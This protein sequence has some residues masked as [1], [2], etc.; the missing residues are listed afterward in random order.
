[1]NLPEQATCKPCTAGGKPLTT[2]E[3]DA[4]LQQL[5]GWC[6]ESENA[7]AQLSKTYLFTDFDQALVFTNQIDSIAR[8]HDHH[9]ALLT[10]WGK[11]TIRWW[12]HSVSGL[13]R[14]D[15][16]MAARTDE[17]SRQLAKTRSD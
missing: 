4:L 15:F 17:A 3:C 12:T 5:T 16:I 9:P 14:N 11:V 8:Q 7:V 10:E 2:A 13:Q 6:I 1:M